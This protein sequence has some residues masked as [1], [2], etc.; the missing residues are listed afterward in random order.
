MKEKRHAFCECYRNWM[1]EDWKKVIP[2]MK[3]ISRTGPVCEGGR[4]AWKVGP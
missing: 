4:L 3:A 2:V 1:V